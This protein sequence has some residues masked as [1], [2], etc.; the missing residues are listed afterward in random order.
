M[1]E[2]RI[3]EDGGR[4]A[5]LVDGVVQS[6]S[7]EDGLASGGYWAAMVPDDQPPRRGLILGLGGGTLARLLHVR[8]GPFPIIGVDDDPTI[9]ALA[10]QAGWL[11]SEDLEIVQADAFAYVQACQER[12]DYIAVDLFRGEQLASRAFGKPFLR[13]LRTLLVPRGRLAINLFS[14]IRMLTRVARIAAFFDVRDQRGVGGNLVVH[15]QRR[16]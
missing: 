12:F 2:V 13:R 8:W 11:P 7:P 16:R 5:L 15:A 4:A 1:P 14:D 10:R 3:G 6:I 9:V